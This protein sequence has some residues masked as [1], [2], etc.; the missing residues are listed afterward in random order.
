MAYRHRGVPR[1]GIGVCR[2]LS[3]DLRADGTWGKVQNLGPPV[4]TKANEDAPFIHPNKKLLFFTT[5]G[6]NGMGGNDI[7]KSE[8]MD[9]IIKAVISKEVKVTSEKA[10]RSFIT[11]R[12]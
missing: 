12:T 11:N 7:Y 2:G 5:D 4:N 10:L 3:A 9:D 6:H 8:L 1:S